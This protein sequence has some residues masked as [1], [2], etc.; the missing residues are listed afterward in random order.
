LAVRSNEIR[1][2]GAFAGTVLGGGVG[3]IEDLHMAIADRSFGRADSR[4]RN[5]HDGIAGAVYGS[6]AAA[7]RGAVRFAAAA[8]GTLSHPDAAPLDSSARMQ[9]TLG[10]L[11]GMWGDRLAHS[12][13]TL[14]FPTT[15]RH[16]GTDLAITPTTIAATFP[17]A[18]SRLVVFIHGLCETDE[19]W[20]V[21][22]DDR[23]LGTAVDFG[24]RLDAR[25]RGT[26]LYLRYNSGRHVSASGADVADLLADLVDAWPQPVTEVV[27]VGHSMGGLVARSAC[28]HADQGG[29]PWVHLV[30]HVVCLGTPHL[31]APL[32][33]AV[34][35]A[36]WAL[37]TL[38]ETRGLA[39]ALNARSA[40]VKDLRFGSLVEQD[41]HGV[42]PDAFLTGRASEVPFLPHAA[43][44]FVAVTVSRNRHHPLGVLLGDLLVQFPSASGNGRRRQ[45]PFEVENGHHIGGLNHFQ[46]LTHPDVY[47]QLE[48]WLTDQS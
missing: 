42:D 12:D 13:N 23:D 16:H 32:E 34:N 18:S 33:K 46:L 38:P 27:L 3:L 22:V 47:Q 4:A 11:N 1:D 40:G 41:W 28:H 8:A 10:A 45:L 25:G 9:A 14:A 19:S 2:A 5:V 36:S 26:P 24:E 7:A 35:I 17:G 39:G 29:M 44:Y 37:H 31:G 48:Y 30:R 43:Y 21:G 20:H 6:I 15:V